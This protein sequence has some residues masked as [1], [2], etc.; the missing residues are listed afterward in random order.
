MTQIIETAPEMHLTH[1]F[2]CGPFWAFELASILGDI[3]D[4]EAPRYGFLRG[5]DRNPARYGGSQV[6]KATDVRM[7]YLPDATTPGK[8]V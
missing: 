7:E 2:P 3:V 4:Q 6:C 1:R 5:S 8:L